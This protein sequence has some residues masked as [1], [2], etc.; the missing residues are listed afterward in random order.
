MKAPGLVCLCAVLAALPLSPCAFLMDACSASRRQPAAQEAPAAG[1]SCCTNSGQ[2]PANR[3]AR[4][5]PCRGDCCRVLPLVPA[6]EKSA[7]QLPATAVVAPFTGFDDSASGQLL[8]E[9][10]ASPTHSLHVLHCR[11]RC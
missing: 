8:V 7:S 6:A 3:P 1:H 2:R 10:P 4:E 5:A 11:W 9:H